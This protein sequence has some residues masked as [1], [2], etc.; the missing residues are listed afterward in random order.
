MTKTGVSSV[1]VIGAGIIGLS[2]AMALADRG[3]RVTLYDKQWPPR[4]ASWAAAG[5][6]APAFE[7]A[8]DE[9][10]HPLLFDLC[11]ASADL[12]SDWASHL[13][14]RSGV[15]SG[16]HPGP[17]LALA[18]TPLETQRLRAIA[19]RLKNTKQQPTAIDAQDLSQAEPGLTGTIEA[20]Y[21]LPSDGQADN[22]QTL[23]ALVKI[24]SEHPQ[25]SVKSHSAPL[26]AIASGLDHAGHDATL[27]CAGWGT[28]VVAVEENGQNFSLLNWETT[29]DEI[30]CYG[31]QMLSVEPIEGGPRRT[32]RAGALYIVP[33]RDRI[34][35]GATT[36]PGEAPEAADPETTARLKAQAAELFPAL[37]KARTIDSWAGVRPGTSNH[38]PLLGATATPGLYVAS[39]HYR[40][41]ILLAPITAR[42]MADMIVDGVISPLAAAF[43]PSAFLTTRV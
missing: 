40:N 6:L 15:Q 36:Q 13:Q 5:M 23:S 2:C 10:V 3:L 42:I 22:R 33:K 39:G 35:I 8:G 30:D 14:N 34:V 4:G 1:A 11:A 17:S 31:G 20:A 18:R 19:E 16:Y 37:A 41:G 25:I 32:A 28:G 9:G 29:L 26:K 7:A 38:A 24:A 43:A 27:V 21:W 12:W